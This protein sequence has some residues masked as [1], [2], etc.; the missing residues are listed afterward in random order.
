MARISIFYLLVFALLPVWSAARK[1]DRLPTINC[2]KIDRDL[3]LSGKLDDPL[4]ARTET[5]PLVSANDGKPMRSAAT[6]RMLYNDRYVYVGFTCEDDYI[7][8]TMMK[9][10]DPIYNEEVVEVF[11]SPTGFVRNYYEVEVSPLNTVAD[12]FVL[13]GKPRDS[14]SWANFHTYFEHDIDGLLTMTHVEGEL[15]KPG[16]GKSW[17]VEMAIPI[18]GLIGPEM[19]AP[20]P[21]T[22]WRLNFFRV[23]IPEKDKYEFYAWSP[24]MQ[25]NDLHRP[26]RFGYVVFTEPKARIVRHGSTK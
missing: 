11:L 3:V 15:N 18:S 12:T 14:L 6:A 7:W 20:K 16:A 26:W 13:N 25:P 19:I 10:D 22:K 1:T 24:I 8:G 4:W 21:G 5:A 17:S 23:D 9:R 2:I